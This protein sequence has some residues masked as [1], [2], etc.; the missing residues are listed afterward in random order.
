MQNEISPSLNDHFQEPPAW[1]YPAVYWFWHHIPDP[2]QIEQQLQEIHHAGCRTFLIQPRLS[3][4]QKDYLSP[5]YLEAYRYAMRIASEIGLTAGLY[6]DYNWISGHAGGQTVTGREHLRERHLF[7]SASSPQSGNAVCTISGIHN[8]LGN[9]LGDAFN[10]W[11]YEGGQPR[12]GDWQIC[13]AYALIRESAPLDVSA[14]SRI[15]RAAENGCQVEINLPANLSAADTVITFIEA[16][17]LTSRLVNYLHPE[18]ADSFIQAGYEP[19]RQAVGDYFGDPLTFLFIDQPYA[20]FYTWNEHFGNP[21]NSLMF[22]ES[23]EQAYQD[24]RGEDIGRALL[25]LVLPEAED[26][27]RLRCNFYETY[28]ELA[29]RRFLK[30]VSDWAKQ[31]GLLFT[32]HELLGFVG[33][34]GFADGLPALD[35]RVNFGADYFAADAYKD[36]SAVDACNYH[37]QV[38]ARF[39]ASVS[40]AHGRRGC[41]IEQYSVPVGRT[42]PAPAG[43]WDLTLNALRSQAVR[44]LLFGASQFLFHAYYQTNDSDS[45]DTPL[46]S[47]RFDFPPGINYEPWFRFHPAFAEELARL[48]VFL[49]SAEA[50]TRTAL[51]Y[52]LRTCWHGGPGHPF[53]AESRFWNR[54][55]SGHGIQYDIIREE[56]VTGAELYLAGYRLLVLPGVEV[57]QNAQFAAGLAAFISAGGRIIASGPLPAFTQ[58]ADEQ[59]ALREQI[60]VLFQHHPQ[61]VHYPD[62]NQAGQGAAL[63]SM[64]NAALE[65]LHVKWDGNADMPVWNWQGARPG[66][67]CVALFNDSPQERVAHINANGCFMPQFYDPASSEQTRWGWYTQTDTQ[68]Q[69]DMPLKPHA[70]VCLRLLSQETSTDPH[71]I[72]IEGGARLQRAQQEADGKLVVEVDAYSAGQTSLLLQSVQEPHVQTEQCE[73]QVIPA[74]QDLWQ[75]LL[76]IPPLPQP[77]LLEQEWTLQFPR[78]FRPRPVDVQQGWENVQPHYAGVG[79]YRCHF[80]MQTDDLEYRWEL[81]FP[82]VNTALSAYL[83]QT[84]LGARGWQPYTFNLPGNALKLAYNLLEIAVWNTAGN[85]FYPG[86]PYDGGL[87]HPAGLLETPQLVPSI[88]VMIIATN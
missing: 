37:P 24:E 51:L 76:N 49:S 29:R 67:F 58:V 54:W 36:I 4:P 74:G 66:E 79:Y 69:V 22:D 71:V 50:Q 84:W 32:G 11:V 56:Q 7:W 57:V 59:P 63:Q 47:P 26:S 23:L 8:N 35:S 2:R 41:I 28:G 46:R 44:H 83:N 86:T 12:W 20:G 39:G 65:T 33:E 62:W 87:L 88:R 25:G 70:V 82:A 80:P 15:S 60:E 64:F 10:D 77:R 72:R 5:E 17:C 21:L 45:A 3:F 68:T 16:R 78:E 31:N 13:R 43:Q 48:N 14:Y 38:S 52:P 85:A 75:V 55:L 81:C 6:D 27:A 40:R 73:A 19:Y 53:N 30:P 18:T 61:A 9:G 42:L 1:A 34:W